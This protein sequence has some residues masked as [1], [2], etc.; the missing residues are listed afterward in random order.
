MQDSLICLQDFK[1]VFQRQI[2]NIER[3][4]LCH[5]SRNIFRRSEACLEAEVGCLRLCFDIGLAELR[6][7][8]GF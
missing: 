4:W 3:K 7:K 1:G 6:G 2:A 5:V 8:P